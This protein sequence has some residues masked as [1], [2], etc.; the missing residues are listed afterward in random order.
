VN[1]LVHS[2][3]RAAAQV[4]RLVVIGNDIPAQ[5]SNTYADAGWAGINHWLNYETRYPTRNECP[6]FEVAREFVRSQKLTSAN[7]WREFAK[8]DRRPADIP[9]N[10]HVTY[11][12]K[13]WI[14]FGDWPG[15]GVI[16]ARLRRYRPFEDAQTWARSLKL[17][18]STEWRAYARAGKLP[19]D[20]PAVSI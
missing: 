7:D 20:I 6:S 17:N 19:A 10:P 15:T 13:G 9:T 2:G 16:A 11:R 4:T 3:R 12:G 8:S 1:T 18:S 5:P 14:T